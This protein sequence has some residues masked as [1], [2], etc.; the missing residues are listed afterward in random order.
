MD[1]KTAKKLSELRDQYDAL[2]EVDSVLRRVMAY[3]RSISTLP[4]EEL[5]DQQK[6]WLL[7]YEGVNAMMK[8]GTQEST[9]A[10]ALALPVLEAGIEKNIQ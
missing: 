8:P 2:D 9:Q 5:S 7:G 6:L 3:H 10:A 1:E 4:S